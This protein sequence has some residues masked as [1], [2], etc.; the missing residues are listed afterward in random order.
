MYFA[1]VARAQIK[2]ASFTTQVWGWGY[3]NEVL[4]ELPNNMSPDVLPFAIPL[5]NVVQISAGLSH[6]AALLWGGQ[7][8]DW[9]YWASGI[10]A[11]DGLTNIVS[12]ACGELVSLTISSDG[13]L[14]PWGMYL[15]RLNAPTNLTNLVEISDDNSTG[16]NGPGHQIA[17]RAN[18]TVVP[19]GYNMG[20]YNEM[21]NVPT[22]L[23]NAVS[24]TAGYYENL[25]ICSD[26]SLR[27]LGGIPPTYTNFVPVPKDMRGVVSASTC[28]GHDLVLLD[29]GKVIAW[30]ENQFGQCNVPANLGNVVAVSAG[31][32]F[33]MALQED[34]KVIAW[35]YNRGG[36][37]NVPS[38][39][40]DVIAISAGNGYCLA[41]TSHELATSP[42]V[43]YAQPKSR[44]ADIHGS[45]YLVAYAT[46]FPVI[47][48]QWLKDGHVIPGA[49]QKFLYFGNIAPSD[50]GSYAV[51]AQNKFGV[52]MSEIVTLN[53]ISTALDIVMVPSVRIFGDIGG[54]YLIQ[55]TNSAENNTGWKS[56]V[57]VILTNS[58]EW[59]F[60]TS[61]VG[62]PERFYRLQKVP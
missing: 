28:G 43:I 29:N 6:A 22:D 41:L 36:E 46:G 59:Y 44:K 5:T 2:S 26:G 42:P 23:T 56:L 32:W 37:C 1:T 14:K 47:H 55:Y 49:T 51:L 12:I 3:D 19:W 61:G 57:T 53:P 38:N 7:V 60:D 34:G 21:Y 8:R 9:G 16:F 62:E 35:G 11:S 17:L 54:N 18:G 10:E 45:T 52:T 40:R 31:A 24:I 30:G 48:Y 39:M 4:N 25:V 58:P 15:D 27:I 50:F 33:S 13:L 20:L